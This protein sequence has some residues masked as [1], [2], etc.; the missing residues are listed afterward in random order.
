[1]QARM[2]ESVRISL[3]RAVRRVRS[4]IQRGSLQRDFGRIAL[5]VVVILPV[6]NASSD[7]RRCLESLVRHTRGP[8]RL[9]IVDDASDDPAVQDIL[10]EYS[11]L[12]HVT[13]LR[14]SSNLGY[15]RAVNLAIRGTTSDV[16]LL[17]S[18]VE[19]GPGWLQELLWTASSNETMGTVTALSNNAGVFSAPVSGIANVTPPGLSRE[20]VARLV[21]QT[22]IRIRPSTPTAHG[23]C[24]Y[25]KR[26]LLD[27]VGV[28]D[29]LRFPRGYGEENDLSLRASAKGWKHKI[30]DSAYVFHARGR[31]F[32]EQRDELMA[33]ARVCISE[34]YPEY[35]AL[36]RRFAHSRDMRRVRRHLQD[37]FDTAASPLPRV[38][39]LCRERAGGGPA[40]VADELGSMS[41]FYEPYCLTSTTLTLKLW[42]GTGGRWSEIT[43][44][45]L[46]TRWQPTDI[47]RDDYRVIAGEVLGLH[48][49]ELIDVRDRL[50]HTLDV[51]REAAR[52]GIPTIISLADSALECP[53][54]HLSDARRTADERWVHS[55]RAD[56]ARIVA[57]ASAVVMGSDES[58]AALLEKVPS[59]RRRRVGRIAE[60]NDP[61]ATALAARLALYA[62]VLEEE[63]SFVAPVI[64]ERCPARRAGTVRLA[65]VVPGTRGRYPASTHV[66]VFRRLTHPLVKRHI[67]M[68]VVPGE[69]VEGV[70]ARTDLVLVQRTALQPAAAARLVDGLQRRGIP[71][72][73]E[74]DDDLFAGDTVG[75]GNGRGDSLARLL[76]A[77]VL[78]TVSTDV[79]RD[80]V[81]RRAADVVVI[82]NMLDED[83]WLP[84]VP[85][86]PST[87]RPRVL[88]FGTP[89]HAEDIALLRP[90]IERLR[91]DAGVDVTLTVIGIEPEGP[92]QA[93]Y[94]RMPIPRHAVDYPA[95][96]R[97]L[98]RRA[99]EFDVGLAPLADSALNRS[100]SDLKFLEYA[101]LGL[102]AVLS[103]VPAYA[104]CSAGVMGLKVPNTV[105]AWAD[106]LLRLC[107]DE[108]LRTRL[109]HSSRDYAFTER[110]LGHTAVEFADLLAA[111]AA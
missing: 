58:Q 76:D 62:T 40:L 95:F 85:R 45:S 65:A 28:F 68:S 10:A 33:R 16:V 61:L 99:V 2:H 19:V 4:G 100:K 92:D 51:P 9:V 55:C 83:L 24:V 78:A 20:A 96:V 103:D 59:L 57:D 23:F 97:W 84:V 17:N 87:G 63:R 53:T 111:T 104:S 75:A 29:E 8:A 5:P 72:I 102:P 70:S 35:D 6:Y 101:A 26:A 60:G 44:W 66:R 15:T 56:L 50:G 98:K 82:P 91:R 108:A 32:G 109:A 43:R 77:S 13:V 81:S 89:T 46:R 34:T 1:M 90:V 31:S 67:A 88:Y 12:A 48:A 39:I 94:S 21:A 69:H 36:V 37:V 110:C 25:I 22:S 105:D 3:S 93:W 79:L 41:K 42:R 38:L 18:D 64:A 14:Q 7:L 80:I 47:E 106:A 73:V 54:V 11:Q 74:L 107:K 49:I 52:V 71:L 30:S 86:R 27:D